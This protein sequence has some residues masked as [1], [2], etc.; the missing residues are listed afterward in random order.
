MD[1]VTLEKLGLVGTFECEV[2]REN[3]KP[4]WFYNGN[5]IDRKSEKYEIKSSNGKHSLSINNCTG[6][7]EGVYSVKFSDFEDCAAK[8]FVKG[9]KKETLYI[10]FRLILYLSFLVPP[11]FD[12]ESIEQNLTLHAGKSHVVEF[13]FESYPPPEVVWK[14]NG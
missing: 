3:L 8:L 1:D 11:K 14:F 13:P 5:K 7:D 9:K 6:E 10:F 2:T 12:M 4:E